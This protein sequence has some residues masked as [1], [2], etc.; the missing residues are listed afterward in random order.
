[1]KIRA[2]AAVLAGKAFEIVE[3]DLVAHLVQRIGGGSGWMFDA[4]GNV[5]VMRTALEPAH[6]GCDGSV[7]IGVVYW[8]NFAVS[9]SLN[10]SCRQCWAVQHKGAKI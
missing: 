2:A 10:A 9:G 5:G 7:V 8:P 3:G 6:K 1:M 4:I